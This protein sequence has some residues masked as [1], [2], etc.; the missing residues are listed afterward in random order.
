MRI[1]KEG[2]A[3]IVVCTLVFAAINMTAFHF[4]KDSVYSWIVLWRYIWPADFH[5]FVFPHSAPP[6]YRRR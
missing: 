5:L 1:H 3:T 4:L 2:F 6:F